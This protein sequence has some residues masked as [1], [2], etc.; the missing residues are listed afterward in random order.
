MFN[1]GTAKAKL[2]P[3]PVSAKMIEDLLCFIKGM[4]YIYTAVGFW[5]PHCLT[6]LIK[7]LSSR[8]LAI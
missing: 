8:N 2:F 1:I 3:L 6:V 5:Y 7:N 4:A